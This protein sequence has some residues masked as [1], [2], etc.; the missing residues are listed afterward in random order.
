MVLQGNG[1][2]FETIE[3]LDG[4][5]VVP[6]DRWHR[7]GEW[8]ARSL[9]GCCRTSACRLAVLCGCGLP[10]TPS[11]RASRNAQA[12]RTW[13][14]VLRSGFLQ[15]YC[16]AGTASVDR[17][18]AGWERSGALEIYDQMQ[19]VVDTV[20]QLTPT[21][22]RGL[23]PDEVN[24]FV[25]HGRSTVPVTVAWTLHLVSRD[26]DL[27]AS[28]AAELDAIPEARPL[29]VAD[30]EHLPRLRLTVTESLRLFPPR[31]AEVRRVVDPVTIAAVTIPR[32]PIMLTSQWLTHRLSAAFAQPE[33]CDPDRFRAFLPVER[34]L[35]F[36]PFGVDRLHRR[37]ATRPSRRSSCWSGPFCGATSCGRQA[38]APR[39]L[40][41]GDEHSARAACDCQL[42]GASAKG[43]DL[44]T[45][46]H[47]DRVAPWFAFLVHPRDDDD[48]DSLGPSSVLRRYS[49]PGE[50]HRRAFAMGPLVIGEVSFGFSSI[51]GELIGVACPSDEMMTRRGRAAVLASVRTAVAR[52][53]RVIG[54]GALTA[55]A[56]G[57]GAMLVRDLPPGVTVTNGSAYTAAVVWRQVLS[58][59]RT[60]PE[61][62]R[63]VT[64]IVGC[65]GSVGAPATRLIAAA[66]L[67]LVLVG[68]TIERV[69]TVIPDVTS[70]VRTQDWAIPA[71]AIS[72]CSSRTSTPHCSGRSTS[73]RARWSSTTHNRRTSTLK[74]ARSSPGRASPWSAAVRSRFRV[75][76]QLRVGRRRTRC[77]VRLPR[78]DLPLCA[79]RSPWSR[80][81]SAERRAGA[82]PRSPGEARRSQA[83]RDHERRGVGR[84]GVIDRRCSVRARRQKIAMAAAR[85]APAYS[86]LPA[87]A[88]P[89]GW[90]VNAASTLNCDG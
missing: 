27:A 18:M 84:G 72:S 55:P 29:S 17:E 67:P 68:R 24:R 36:Y 22:T 62:S 16:A 23:T 52:G 19:S 7:R 49:A 44:A 90:S 11:Q 87:A 76:R 59:A 71:A 21:L 37:S 28:L 2:A 80:H 48:P 69:R 39:C 50:F 73:N 30:L 26:A 9:F 31:W 61:G 46:P 3:P 6:G 58:A 12:A 70:A 47:L 34:E 43:G 45:I 86:R 13:T 14:D 81:G 85:N 32:G 10:L 65:T 33:R 1:D 78:R 75:P 57:G 54:L 66:S 79:A 74:H 20:L 83:R 89:T 25:N 41:L 63:V 53:A 77:H 60:W 64:G 38:Q 4:N 40:S 42:C 15:R 8:S 82:Q 51:K 88:L 35:A 5:S 56:T